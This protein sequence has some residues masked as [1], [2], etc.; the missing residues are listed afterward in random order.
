MAG[1]APPT[2]AQPPGITSPG[3]ERRSCAEMAVW[4]LCLRVKIH[5]SFPIKN[6]LVCPQPLLS[7]DSSRQLPNRT[8]IDTD[9]LGKPGISVL[10]LSAFH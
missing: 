1:S 7:Y 3:P 6:A 9:V 8:H 4:L 2:H 10:E 5:S